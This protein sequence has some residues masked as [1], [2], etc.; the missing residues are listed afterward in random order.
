MNISKQKLSVGGAVLATA[1]VSGLAIAVQQRDQSEIANLAK[2]RI[3]LIDAINAAHSQVPGQLLS[4]ALDDENQPL[5]FRVAVVQQDKIIETLVDAQ[6]GLVL[7][8]KVDKGDK[9][10]ED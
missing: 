1:L 4:A 6:T 8:M 9:G 2:T 7:G 5:A 10:D 3:T